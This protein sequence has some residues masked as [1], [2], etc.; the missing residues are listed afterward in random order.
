MNARNR[1]PNSQAT[2]G[3]PNHRSN[4]A[5]SISVD[6]CVGSHATS[7]NDDSCPG[8]RSDHGPS[9]SRPILRWNQVSP[10]SSGDRRVEGDPRHHGE[11]R[12]Q[13]DDGAERVRGRGV[14][15]TTASSVVRRVGARR[16]RRA[17]RCPRHPASI[18]QTG[19]LRGDSRGVGPT[20]TRSTPRQARAATAPG[21]PR[22]SSRRADP[23]RAATTGGTGRCPRPVRFR[24]SASRA[25]SSSRSPA[26]ETP[27]PITTSSGSKPAASPASPVPSQ[28][29]T[30]RRISSA[31]LVALL[32][33]PG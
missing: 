10:L 29:P 21:P 30:A 19:R 16:A 7:P 24:A 13:R 2:P 12:D 15:S 14:R 4:W 26:S 8:W 33:R 23:S 5:A 22:R 20:L 11:Q 6:H 9:S 31:A 17:V 27:P 18:R 28:V 32:A 1:A 25:G 3:S